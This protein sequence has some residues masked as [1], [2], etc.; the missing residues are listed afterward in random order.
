MSDDV[1]SH[2][3]E[4]PAALL[5]IVPGTDH[6]RGFGYVP[7]GTLLVQG[8]ALRGAALDELGILLEQAMASPGPV[9][10][11]DLSR[12]DE[13]S[14]LAQAML[15]HTARVLERRGA[16]LLL[17]GASEELRRQSRWLGVFDRVESEA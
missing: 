8:G 5:A 14:T 10:R 9:V 4:A 3:D 6:V 15:L 17:V 12:V 7:G 1:A 11:I 13:W 2:A 16:C